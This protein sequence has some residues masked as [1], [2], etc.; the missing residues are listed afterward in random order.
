MTV[1]PIQRTWQTAFADPQ[2]LDEL[3]PR[4]FKLK[5][6]TVLDAV[7]AVSIIGPIGILQEEAGYYPQLATSDGEHM[8]AMHDYVVRMAADELPP[9]GAF[10]SLTLYDLDQG[11]SSPTSGRSTAGARTPA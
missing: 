6:Q 8:N 9:A 11:F 10:W 5:D 3:T 7:L 2:V 4:M 1:Y